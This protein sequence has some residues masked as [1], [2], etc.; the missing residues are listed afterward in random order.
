MAPKPPQRQLSTEMGQQYRYGPQQQDDLPFKQ[1][2]QQHH[3]QL[4]QHSQQQTQQLDSS[5]NDAAILFDLTPQKNL[6]QV[7][8]TQD[9]KRKSFTDTKL[10]KHTAL[11]YINTAQKFSKQPSSPLSRRH[12]TAA[13]MLP[14]P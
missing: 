1:Q 7:S 5:T 8:K 14:S 3:I 9:T 10:A 6:K 12:K 2:K 11:G 4:H 13:A